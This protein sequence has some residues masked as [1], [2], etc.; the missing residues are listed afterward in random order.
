MKRILAATVCLLLALASG[1]EF[2]PVPTGSAAT[3]AGSAGQQT[4]SPAATQEATQAPAQTT[5]QAPAESPSVAPSA[6]PDA[7]SPAPTATPAATANKG[8]TEGMIFP[9]SGDKPLMW[10]DL[11]AL[12]ADKLDLAR[13][14]IFARRG[15]KFTKQSYADYFSKFDWYAV[16]PD[17]D[18]NQFSEIEYANIHLIQ[19][20]EQAVKGGL[21]YVASGMKLDFDQDGELET[22]TYS[23]PDENHMKVSIADGKKGTQWNF[24]SEQPIA[25]AYIGDIDF[26]DGM[27]DLFIGEQGPSSD[28]SVYV[29]GIQ[30]GAFLQRGNMPGMIDSGSSKNPFKLNGKGQITTLERMDTVGTDFF[31]SRY[32]LSGSG[33]LVSYP[34]ANYKF[35]TEYKVKTKVALTLKKESKSSSADAF[36]VP[37]GTTVQFLSTDAKNWVQIKAPA[38]TAWLELEAPLKLAH[39]NIPTYEAFD[40]L[41]MAD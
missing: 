24:N 3:P 1:C 8:S 25:K 16:D 33:K 14:E 11:I 26:T 41:Y 31:I 15:Y 29:A 12:D 21:F 32:K 38:G 27:L 34:L 40:G 23:A 30:H 36:T 17:F 20:A 39:P 10:K 19:A 4:P 37:A 35:L 18:Q 2:F 28:Y 7:A 22:L 6:S 13:N 5:A 9:E